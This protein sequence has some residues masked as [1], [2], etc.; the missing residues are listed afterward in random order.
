MEVKFEHADADADWTLG[1]VALMPDQT[2][3]Y[4]ASEP[5]L[6]ST[7]T[8]QLCL[9]P[10]L[11]TAVPAASLPYN[12]EHA[13]EVSGKLSDINAASD[14]VWTLCPERAEDAEAW[15]KAINHV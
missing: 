8:H 11:D 2:L 12:Y 9:L 15:M 4:F 13:F 7:P 14:A 3:A 5:S 10:K 1:Y 6:G